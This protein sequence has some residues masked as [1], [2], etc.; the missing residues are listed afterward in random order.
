MSKKV[1]LL[2][3]LTIMMTAV[4]AMAVKN[5]IVM[6]PDGCSQSVQTLARWYKINV[7]EDP[8]PMAVDEMGVS[9]TMLTYMSNSIITGSAA[10]AT[11]F[12]AGY[13]TTV[14]FLGV[15]P[16]PAVQPHLTG[17][18]S[19]IAPYAPVETVLEAAQRRGKSTGLISTSRITHATPAAY[20]CHIE[21]RGM[22]NE[23][24]EQMVYNNLDVAFGGG[25][26]HLFPKT[27][28]DGSSF[29]YVTSFGDVWGGKRTDG[30]NLVDVLVDRGYQ[31]IDSVDQMMAVNSGRVWGLFDDSH[32]DPEM[33]RERFNPHQPSLA[34]MTAKAIELLS[35]NHNGFFLMVE[36][37]QVDWAGHAN[38]PGYMVTDFLAFDD[39]CRVA[40][41]FAKNTDTLVIGFPDH[42]CGGLTLGHEQSDFSPYYVYTTIEDIAQPLS[43]MTMSCF[44]LADKITYEYFSIMDAIESFW[45]ILVTPEE[46]IEIEARALEV[47]LSYAI[48]EIVSK[49]H[50]NCGWTSHNHTGED[51]VI[52]SYARNAEDRP[53][54]TFDNTDV[55]FFI[56]DALGVN[57]HGSDAWFELNDDILDFTDPANPVAVL[58]GMQFP[59]GK[60]Y[61]INWWGKER[62]LP[63]VTVWN[64]SSD[65]VYI[66]RSILGR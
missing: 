4:P 66:A 54:G 25:A 53:V 15:G 27:N 39:A 65:K 38:D 30:E 46:V 29:E 60:D 58:A 9:G 45:G 18:T 36:G 32:L 31:F 49:Y 47:G 61:Y 56:A 16:D 50:T 42:N 10:A 63:G 8:S 52:W 13:K 14:R 33:D 43:G 2:V 55:A 37:S 34:E 6:I 21:D 26:R 7:L 41:E 22:D 5:V 59:V 19:P 62:K 44:A 12:S 40:M 23:I 1:T 20:A 64:P 24:M 11:G 3:L 57:L 35:Q 51:V 17:F 48:S 28:P